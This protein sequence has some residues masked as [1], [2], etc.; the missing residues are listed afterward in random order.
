MALTRR[1]LVQV[2]LGGSLV[3]AIGG[4]GLSLQGTA[5]RPAPSTLQVLDARQFAILSAL[6][7]ALIPPA[8]SLP[9]PDE[10]EVASK[11]DGLLAGL[12]PAVGEEFKQALALIENPV[13]GLIFDR[14]PRPF[15]QCSLAQRMAVLERWRSS[16]LG[17]RRQVFVAIS[18][19][20][21]AC[22]WGDPRT[23]HHLGYPGPPE[24]IQTLRSAE[25]DPAG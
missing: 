22:Y 5:R 20:V 18:G 7:E 2:G 9:S 11:I 6:A 10:I 4:V 16:R 21:S 3:L 1:R 19:L 12:H 14:R 23:F 25:V 24:W 15:S 13:A 17:L 8:P